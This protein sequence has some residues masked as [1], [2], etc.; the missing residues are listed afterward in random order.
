ML[1]CAFIESPDNTQVHSIDTALPGAAP[2]AAHEEVP[3]DTLRRLGPGWPGP[4]CAFLC[5]NDCKCTLICCT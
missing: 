3:S 4:C 2:D 1:S 5:A